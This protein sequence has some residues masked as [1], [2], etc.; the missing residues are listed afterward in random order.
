MDKDDELNLAPGSADIVIDFSSDEGAL[1]AVAIAR[2]LNTALLVGTTGLSAATRDTIARESASRA[3][4]IASNTSLGVAVARRLVHE[5]ARLLPGF[6]IDIVETHHTRKID[7]PSGT[8][9]SLAD[10]VQRALG[11]ALPSDRIHAIRAGDVVGDHVVSF[12]GP[13]ERLEIG[14]FAT[15]RDLFALGALRMGRWLAAQKPGM[16]TTD[17]WFEHFARAAL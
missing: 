13:G 7:A 11:A 3:V 4:L 15:S 2:E 9:R 17:E 16:H 14:H 6:D 1:R 5:A 10:A 8:A 12:C